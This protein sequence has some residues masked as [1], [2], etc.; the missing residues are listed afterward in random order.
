[1]LQA[2]ADVTLQPKREDRKIGWG[3][4]EWRSNLHRKIG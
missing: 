3:G 2:S 1:L 4:A